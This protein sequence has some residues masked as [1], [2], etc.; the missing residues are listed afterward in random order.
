MKLSMIL[1]MVL[2][3]IMM[4]GCQESVEESPDKHLINSQLINSYHD[5]AMQNAIVSEHTLYPYHFVKNG[6]ELNEIGQR[7][8]AVLTKHFMQY[9]G[10]LNIRRHNSPAELYEARVKLVRE[11]LQQ[12]GIDME[13]ISISD[14]MP[15]GAGMASERILIILEE[16]DEG[17]STGT[18]TTF[19]TGTR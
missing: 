19:Q 3:C 9:P 5:I 17:V 8:L 12:A 2:F 18:S 6:A 15:G 16:A 14:D 13:R 11:G 10:K 1:T 4:I 7:D